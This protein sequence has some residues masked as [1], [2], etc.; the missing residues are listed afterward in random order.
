VVSDFAAL[1]GVISVLRGEGSAD[2]S[3]EEVQIVLNTDYRFSQLTDAD[4]GVVGSLQ[5]LRS[6]SLSASPLG[7]A[8]MKSLAALPRLTKLDVGYAKLKRA[9][10]AGIAAMSQLRWFDIAGDGK[11]GDADIDALLGLH[12]LETVKLRETGLTDAGISRLAAVPSIVDIEFPASVTDAGLTAIASLPHL[13]AVRLPSKTTDE[14]LRALAAAARLEK[15]SLVLAKIT[16]ASLAALSSCRGLRVLDLSRCSKVTDEGVRSLAACSELEELSLSGT[17]VT[18][19]ALA[20]L[21]G[22][23]KLRTLHIQHQKLT[24]NDVP[25]LTAIASLKRVMLGRN[26]FTGPGLA[27]LKRALP[28]CDINTLG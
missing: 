19:R 5:E 12:R 10:Y 6:I 28:G 1:N 2:L 21:A 26:L 3:A 24:D 9:A 16:D 7:P 15:V 27:A 14:G 20:A 23:P 18:G 13:I 25:A 17:K 11:F 8:G 22:L 4:A